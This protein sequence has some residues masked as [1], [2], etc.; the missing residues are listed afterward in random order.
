MYYRRKILLA[1][2]Q[3][4]EGRIDKISLQKLLFLLARQQE[5]KSFHFAPCK[6][7]CF[8]FQANADLHTLVKY[9]LVNEL[10]KYWEKADV[11][12]YFA[13][14]KPKDQAAIRFVKRQFGNLNKDELITL[15]YKKYPFF[16]IN[17]TIAEN[18]LNAEEM[19]KVNKQR[20][21]ET[22]IVLFT[23]GYEGISL[24]EYL[25]KLIVND[26]KLLC[27]VRKNSLSMKY[28]FSKN[29][30]E[31]ACKGVG[32]EYMHI[33]EVGI[34]PSKRQQLNT[35]ADYDKLFDFYRSDVLENETLKQKEILKLLKNKKRIAL[36]CFEANIYQC[37]RKHL[38]ESITKM[39]GCSYVLKHI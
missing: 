14:L 6:F 11:K 12:N 39:A 10:E 16:A 33:P 2:L 27:D 15:T 4:F 34:E 5:Q 28:G 1:L 3:Q 17:S 13:E 36:T 31:K 8:S 25:N 32:I 22:D 18:I 38:A 37:H 26:V 21:L 30:L 9:S 24:E 35:Q 29:Q 23:I 20:P 7:G 19:T